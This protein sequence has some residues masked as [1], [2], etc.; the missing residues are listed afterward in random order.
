LACGRQGQEAGHEAGDENGATH[1]GISVSNGSCS[2]SRWMR[3]RPDKEKGPV[4]WM[5]TGP[6]VRQ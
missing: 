4:P 2:S 5:E 1:G 3:S 6:S